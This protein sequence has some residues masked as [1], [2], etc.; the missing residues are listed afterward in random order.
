MGKRAQIIDTGQLYKCYRQINPCLR[1]LDKK[2]T[3][4][5][6]ALRNV[7][8]LVVGDLYKIKR[9]MSFCEWDMT[10]YSFLLQQEKKP[11]VRF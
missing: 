9:I 11:K 4:L 3:F 5:R 10:D 8:G 7:L 2:R 6:R 1:H